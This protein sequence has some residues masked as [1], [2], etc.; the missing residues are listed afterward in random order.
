MTQD[1]EKRILELVKSIQV[2]IKKLEQKRKAID[3]AVQLRISEIQVFSKKHPVSGRRSLSVAPESIAKDKKEKPLP[4]RA[5]NG[6]KKNTQ[7]QP[8]NE[9]NVKKKVKSRSQSEKRRASAFKP[10]IIPL[11]T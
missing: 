4:K 10:T 7:R 3:K 9:E 5:K 6:M 1:K 2:E 8:N 11:N